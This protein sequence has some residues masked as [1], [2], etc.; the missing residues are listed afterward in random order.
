M[1][2]D[3]IIRNIRID[4]QGNFVE[5]SKD[6]TPRYIIGK[7]Y[8]ESKFTLIKFNTGED[9]TIMNI[10][11]YIDPNNIAQLHRKV[12][13]FYRN[14]LLIRSELLDVNQQDKIHIGTKKPTMVDEY[15]WYE[16]L[17]NANPEMFKNHLIDA[18]HIFGLDE[19]DIPDDIKEGA[20][21][22]DMDPMTGPKTYTELM[23]TYFN[24]T[25]SYRKY[26]VL[27]MSDGVYDPRIQIFHKIHTRKIKNP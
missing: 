16:L 25:K 2:N 14:L 7:E 24:L 10:G 4:A 27:Q 26:L 23:M 17:I 19:A 6:G 15:L 12:N 1:F 18:I 13:R 9:T 20:Y 8:D 22:I 11:D 21:K 5:D 3:Y